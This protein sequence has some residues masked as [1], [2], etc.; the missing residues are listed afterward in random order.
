MEPVKEVVAIEDRGST[1]KT[2]VSPNRE[3]NRANGRTGHVKRV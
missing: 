3:R 2:A 1:N